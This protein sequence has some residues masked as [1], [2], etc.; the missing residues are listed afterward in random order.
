MFCFRH[1][2]IFASKPAAQG[3]HQSTAYKTTRSA[4]N[5]K[6]RGEDGRGG[7]EEPKKGKERE[8]REGSQQQKEQVEQASESKTGVKR[9]V[10][11][12]SSYHRSHAQKINPSLA[13]RSSLT[14]TQAPASSPVDD[15]ETKKR[16]TLKAE[17]F[18]LENALTKRLH[19]TRIE[20]L[21][22]IIRYAENNDY[23]YDVY[24]RELAS[25]TIPSP[26]HPEYPTVA[27]EAEEA[28]IERMEKNGVVE[29]SLDRFKRALSQ[30]V[31]KP[32]YHIQAK[33]EELGQLL[34]VFFGACQSL[35]I[36]YVENVRASAPAPVPAPAPTT[37]KK[38]DVSGSRTT[39]ESEEE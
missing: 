9:K 14:K 28:L 33:K 24:V 11:P 38:D 16:K 4:M 7:A 20:E 3:A 19:D 32:S 1:S 39:T 31:A 5:E 12:S 37:S 6:N 8:N 29:A 18:K 22:S 35:V 25:L 30:E 10:S 21:M 34:D 26:N 17:F 36:Q 13:A 27:A 15:T 23:L 2:N